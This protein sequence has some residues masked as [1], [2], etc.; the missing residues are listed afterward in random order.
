[1]EV[2]AQLQIT[3]NTWKKSGLSLNIMQI[4]ETP[5][6][7]KP[8]FSNTPTTDLLVKSSEFGICLKKGK[9][10]KSL[11][12]TYSV[13]QNLQLSENSPIKSA[14]ALFDGHSGKQACK[15]ASLN[16]IQNIK[17]F[18]PQGLC[19]A[20]QK[21]D[22]E[23]C[24]TLNNK[25]GTTAALTIIDNLTLISAN[26][27]DTKIILVKKHS[28]EVLSYDHLASDKLEQDRIEKAGGYISKVHNINRVCGQLA[29]T[30]SIGD[31][32]L[33]SFLSSSPYIKTTELQA[34]DLAVIL[35]SDGIFE[36][37]S[38]DLVCTLARDQISLDPWQIAESITEEALTTGSKDNVSTLVIKLKKD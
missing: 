32:K 20:F 37:L 27:G 22:S 26:V 7:K 30:R 4:N 10:R 18:D 5:S 25:G 14:F 8:K 19:D 31:A 13:N 16:L 28:H 21:T 6:L 38:I 35:A 12:D 34:E 15:F 36:T 29:I 17:S 9:Y 11:E 23:F 3:K 2:T 24:L 33:K 1:M